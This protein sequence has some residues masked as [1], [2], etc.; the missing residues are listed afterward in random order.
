MI[1]PLYSLSGFA[2]GLLVGMTG[3]G[4]GSLMTPLLILLFG[5]HPATAV[6]TD[7]LYAAATKTGGSLVHGFARSIDWRVVR[8]LACGSIPATV[9]TIAALSL[10]K[11]NGE[12]MRGLITLV[13][14]VA[15]FFTAIVLVFGQAIIAT[16]RARVTAV[17]PERTRAGTVLVGA[18]LGVLVTISSVGA[19]A[20]GV[21][22]LVLLYPQLPMAKIVGSDIAHAVPLT[23]IAGLGHWTM[24]S[25]DWAIILSLLVGS[26]PGIFVGSYFALRIPERALQLVLACTLLV[27]ATRIAYDHAHAASSIFTAFT[28]RAAP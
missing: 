25:V 10:L 19:G 21:I 15:L 18:L 17:E 1:D 6:G 23:L 7:L 13:L 8:R 4:G 9:A 26:L 20:I 14:S 22:A 12:A 28:R 2:V 24:G 27:V 3:V 5:V 16:Y 11:L